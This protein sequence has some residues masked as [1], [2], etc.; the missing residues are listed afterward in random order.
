MSLYPEDETLYS[1]YHVADSNSTKIG[2]YSSTAAFTILIN[3]IRRNE[4]TIAVVGEDMGE[5]VANV[6]GKYT[7]A[8][9]IREGD[10]LVYGTFEYIVVN[11]PKYIRLFNSYKLILNTNNGRH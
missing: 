8:S 10:K 7:N 3:I 6:N 9:N 11:K 2:N 5:Y 4:D 1:V